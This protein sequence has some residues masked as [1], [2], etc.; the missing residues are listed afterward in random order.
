MI[1]YCQLVK[2]HQLIT[3]NAKNLS[4]DNMLSAGILGMTFKKV[5]FLPYTFF[6]DSDVGTGPKLV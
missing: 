2:C 3:R 1:T 6:T 4:A 5:D